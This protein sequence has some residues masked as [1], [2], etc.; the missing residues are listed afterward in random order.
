MH[1]P[2]VEENA[3][4]RVAQ[5]MASALARPLPAE[6]IARAKHHLVDTL[7]A[8]VSGSQL[9]PGRIAIEML[10]AQGGTAEAHVAGSTLV[11]SAI[12]A[13]WANGMAAHADETDDHHLGT[14]THPGAAVVP[15]ALAAGERANANGRELL[16]AIVLGYDVCV[17][18]ARALRVGVIGDGERNIVSMAGVF[19]AAAAAASLLRLDTR[20]MAYVLS[21]AAQQSSGISSWKRDPDHIEK[22]FVFGGMPARDGVSAALLVGA[23]CTGVD[24]VLSGSPSFVSI[25]APDADPRELTHELGDRHEIMG[26]NIKKWGVGGPIQAPLDGLTALLREGLLPAEIARVDVR[27]AAIEVPTV[28]NSTMPD[29][30]LQHILAVLLADG[31]VTFANSHDVARVRDPAV[32]RERNKINLVPHAEF[33]AV[34]PRRPVNIVAV[35]NDGSTRTFEAHEVRGTYNNPMSDREIENKAMDL[36]VPV[37]GEGKSRQLHHTISSLDEAVRIRDIGRM[38]AP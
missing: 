17:R 14:R 25:N 19:G 13:A 15:A 23:G 26:T 2:T 37:L 3:T 10:R 31:T 32:R 34:L 21:Y 16:A 35:L 9:S 4:A 7:S 11:T 6:V 22:A 18:I 36:L 30:C 1:Q 38:L 12:N 24:D 28:N 20:Q 27:I 33:D 29:V 8:M 5:H